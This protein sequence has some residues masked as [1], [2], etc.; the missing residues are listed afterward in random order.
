MKKAVTALVAMFTLS[1]AADAQITVDLSSYEGKYFTC[2]YPADFEADDDP[3]LENMFEAEMD[4]THHMQICLNDVTIAS[5]QEFKEWTK[6]Q[7]KSATIFSGEHTEPVIKGMSM[8]MRM[9]KEQKIY[10]EKEM[11]CI[12]E[13]A[14][15]SPK[16]KKLF[17][18]EIYFPLSDESTYKP[19]ID[20]I[21]DS[22]KEK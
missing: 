4:E 14:K 7:Q 11:M 6:N 19:L 17:A 16:S 22:L 9:V 21:V 10:E 20:R 2:Q 13:F 5:A 3:V 15:V 8:T 1:T 12:Y 18:G